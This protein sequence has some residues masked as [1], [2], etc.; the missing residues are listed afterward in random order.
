M[1]VLLPPTLETLQGPW[2]GGSSADSEFYLRLEIDRTGRGMLTAQFDSGERPA[3]YE[4]LSADLTEYAIQFELW[5]KDGAEPIYLRGTT[6]GSSM[7]LEVG[8]SEH[9]WRRKVVL[10]PERAVLSRIEAVTRRSREVSIPG[11]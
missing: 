3:A 8:N 11:Q 7:E 9:R 10:E 6:Y 4:V 2:L 1:T 5:P